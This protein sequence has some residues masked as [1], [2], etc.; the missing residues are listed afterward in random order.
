MADVH[1]ADATG[2]SPESTGSGASLARLAA[3]ALADPFLAE[4]VGLDRSTTT[5]GAVF[6]NAIRYRPE[7]GIQ[8]VSRS[9]TDEAGVCLLFALPVE[10]GDETVTIYGAFLGEPSYDQLD[11][12]MDA[13]LASA[14]SSLAKH[15]LL[16]VDTPVAEY[17]TAWGQK[18]NAVVRTALTGLDWGG[19]SAEASAKTTPVTTA[20]K[21]ARVGSVSVETTTGTATSPVVLDRTLGDPGPLWRLFTPTVVVPRF[22]G[23]V[24]GKA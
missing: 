5:R 13:L 8:A 20:L 3:L 9:Y 16:A 18:A 15:E 4:A 7:D 21:G 14:P 1:P 11:A 23:W 6:E 12:D 19:R 17:S 2:L 24:T 22:L 10:V